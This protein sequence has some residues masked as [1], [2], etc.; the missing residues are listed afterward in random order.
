MK[1]AQNYRYNIRSRALEQQSQEAWA[2]V[3]PTC[4]QRLKDAASPQLQL[5]PLGNLTRTAR[6]SDIL[7]I[8]RYLDFYGEFPPLLNVDKNSN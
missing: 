1:E 8:A 6:S 7:K 5:L 2:P 3:F 4:A